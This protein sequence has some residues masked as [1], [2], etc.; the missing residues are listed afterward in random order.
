MKLRLNPI[1]TKGDFLSKNAKLT[2]G[3]TP[4]VFD[5]T[6]ESSNTL[7]DTVRFGTKYTPYLS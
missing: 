5:D 2:I 1:L 7:P 6:F 4:I 3:S